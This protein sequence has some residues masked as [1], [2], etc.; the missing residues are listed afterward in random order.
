M[1]VSFILKAKNNEVIHFVFVVA[2][3]LSIELFQNVWKA[4]CSF[5]LTR[6]VLS[7]E[8]STNIR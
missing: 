7:L 2:E 5:P 8:R 3:N 1:V 6:Q 4:I